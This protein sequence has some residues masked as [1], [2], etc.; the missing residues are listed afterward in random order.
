MGRQVYQLVRLQL[1]RLQALTEFR[2]CLESKVW[3]P[4][5]SRP[6]KAHTEDSGLGTRSDCLI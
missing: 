3:I 6:S 1:A 5:C 4:T 2:V